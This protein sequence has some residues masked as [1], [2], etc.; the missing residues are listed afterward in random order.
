AVTGEEYQ[1]GLRRA[2]DLYAH[3]LRVPGV[4]GAADRALRE[5]LALCRGRGTGVTL[6]LMPECSAFRQWATPPARRR[7][8]TYLDGLCRGY[9][10]TVVDARDWVADAGFADGHHLLPAAAAAFSRR[11]G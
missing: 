9:G 7:T 1:K 3:L 11:F 10:L 2:H 6:V 8:R 4:S 5:F